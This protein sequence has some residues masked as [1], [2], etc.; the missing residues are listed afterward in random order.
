MLKLDQYKVPTDWHTREGLREKGQFWTPD[1]IAEAMVEYALA[2]G[3]R[4]LFDPAVGAGAFFRAAKAVSKERGVTLSLAGAEIDQTALAQAEQQGLSAS[5]LAQVRIADFVLDPPPSRL[6][7]IVA[8]PPYIRHH[9]ISAAIKEKLKRLGKEITGKMLDGRAGLH[10]YFLIRALDLLNEDGRLAFI[11]PA[12]TCE[13]IFAGDLWK[14]VARNFCLDA[15][16]TFA[17]GASPFPQVDT[18]PLIFLIR[19]AKPQETLLW[20]RCHE[21]GSNQLRSWIASD[22]G[23]TSQT[24]FSVA[25]RQLDEAIATGLSRGPNETVVG[26]PILGDFAKVLRGVATGANEYF[27]LTKQQAEQFHISPKFLI[28]AIGRTRD[29][30]DD[31]ITPA[32]LNLLAEQGR[33]TWLLSLN[34]KPVEQYPQAI[35]SYLQEGEELGLPQRPLISQRRPWYKMESRVTPPI[36]FAYLGRR[37]SR[38]I[39]NHAG[40][41][42][43]TC[44]LCV[45]PHRGEQDYVQRLWSVLNHPE[46][47]A[48]LPLIGKSYGSGAVKVEP[49]ALERLPLPEHLVAEACLLREERLF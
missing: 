3:S 49:R 15:V 44:F 42:P 40:V 11:M 16:V 29:V 46:T 26:G 25:I 22:F 9:R 41:V 33:P 48:N 18:N 12:D 13:G 4:K 21:A 10:I 14:W 27:F 37:N 39:R 23:S 45:Y 19:K 5:D 20:V 8:N 32:I 6:T 17:S 30:P 31:E 24:T 43:L 7:A 38:F 35:Q 47:I 2:G 1:W 28:P 36:L 34:G